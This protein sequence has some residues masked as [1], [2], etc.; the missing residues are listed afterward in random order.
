MIDSVATELG[1]SLGLA[2][3]IMHDRSKFQKVCPENRRIKKKL[4]ECAC[5]CN[6]SYRMQMKEKICLS[7]TVI[8]I[9][10]YIVMY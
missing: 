2:Y 1:C 7:Y 6:I 5:P 10:L 9:L 3:S 8:V 4:T